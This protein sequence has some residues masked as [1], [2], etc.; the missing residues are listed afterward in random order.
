LVFVC[1]PIKISGYAP[2]TD[3]SSLYSFKCCESIVLYIILL[4][5]TRKFSRFLKRPVGQKV[6]GP[7]CITSFGFCCV[8]KNWLHQTSVWSRGMSFSL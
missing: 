6:V 3:L 5:V 8:H 7:R 4:E 2:G 1:P